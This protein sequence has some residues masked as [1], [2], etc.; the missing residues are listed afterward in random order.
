MNVEQQDDIDELEAAAL[1]GW[2][3]QTEPLL[4]SIRDLADASETAEDFVRGLQDLA[5]DISDDQT[6]GDSTALISSLADAMFKARGIGD[7]TDGD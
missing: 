4:Q 7:A 6:A 3:K 5:D 1:E 2:Q